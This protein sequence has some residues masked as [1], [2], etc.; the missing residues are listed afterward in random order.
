MKTQDA[1]LISLLPENDHRM[2]AITSSALVL[3]LCLSYWFGTFEFLIA[4]PLFA[5][6]PGDDLKV[7]VQMLTPPDKKNTPTRNVERKPQSKAKGRSVESKGKPHVPRPVARLNVLTSRIAQSAHLSAYEMFKNSPVNKDIAKVLR[8]NPALTRS[9]HTQLG[10]PRGK[11]EGGFNTGFGE[12]GDN[13][14]G[15]VLTSVM[16]GPAAALATRT[17]GTLAPPKASEISV[18]DAGSGRSAAEILQVVR[19][20]TPGL[21]H[22]YTRFL[23]KDPNLEGKITLRFTILPGGDIGICEIVDHTTSSDAFAEDIR[24]AVARWTFKPVK[25]GNTT[26]SLPFTFS[27]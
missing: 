20:R 8:N 14:L 7:T 12:G 18:G 23:K 2:R 19:A 6:A 27:E 16:G 26:V 5:K 17:V 1:F 22:I 4:E 15:D 13:A 10:A 21:R 25:S 3:G 24:A 9:G 11:A